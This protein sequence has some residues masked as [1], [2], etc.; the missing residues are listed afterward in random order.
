MF[1]V[2]LQPHRRSNLWMFFSEDMRVQADGVGGLK[3]KDETTQRRHQIH[4]RLKRL[5]RG[6]KYAKSRPGFVPSQQHSHRKN[7]NSLG[8]NCMP[9][10]ELYA[11]DSCSSLF[12]PSY[13]I[14]S[15]RFVCRYAKIRP[16]AKKKKASAA[17][18]RGSRRRTF[19]PLV[20]YFF[21]P[22]TEVHAGYCSSGAL[23]RITCPPLFG[24]KWRFKEVFDVSGLL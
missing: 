18:A 7:K 8:N 12:S 13:F 20:F 21:S 19:V 16:D 24:V 3:M 11:A 23:S 5:E 15:L 2:A 9:G 6:L 4:V 14:Q 10:S 17:R 1:I 22:G